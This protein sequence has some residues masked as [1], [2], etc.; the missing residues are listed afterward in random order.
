MGGILS[1]GCLYSGRES[2]EEHR[3]AVY[4]DSL[5]YTFCFPYPLF[6]KNPIITKEIF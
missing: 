2:K 4:L 1:F 5:P 3:A 6:Q